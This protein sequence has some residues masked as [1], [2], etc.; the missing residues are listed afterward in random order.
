MAD[1]VILQVKVSALQRKLEMLNANVIELMANPE[2][3]PEHIAEARA[4]I[5]RVSDRIK[6]INKQ[7]FEK[8]AKHPCGPV[9]LY[10]V[11][12]LVKE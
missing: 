8:S 10:L 6:E 3:T 2:A 1:R 11:P 4:S 9:K 5:A 7:L 12:K